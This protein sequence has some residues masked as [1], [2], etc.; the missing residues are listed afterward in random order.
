MCSFGLSPKETSRKLARDMPHAVFNML[1][2]HGLQRMARRGASVSFATLLQRA[3]QP[4]PPPPSS[5]DGLMPPPS[6]AFT[7][8]AG[9]RHTGASPG[10]DPGADAGSFAFMRMEEEGNDGDGGF[11]VGL[12]GGQL[13]AAD[14][15][16][17]G[18]LAMDF[19]VA[20]VRHTPCVYCVLLL[21][22]KTWRSQRIC[23]WYVCLCACGLAQPSRVFA[24]VI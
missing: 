4:P 10:R 15:V 14:T 23:T 21:F 24:K 13:H 20:Q 7:G 1:R 22:V 19:G 9:S 16:G 12:N 5:H 11:D 6:T 8:P 18:L 3:Q 2:L 17:L